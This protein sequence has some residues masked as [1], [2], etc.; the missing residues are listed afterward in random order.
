MIKDT[1]ELI[2]RDIYTEM[3]PGHS[4]SV[5]HRAFEVYLRDLL[6]PY[7]TER[8]LPIVFRGRTIGNFRCDLIVDGSTIVELKSISRLRAQE[9]QQL[10]NYM[11][12]LEGHDGILINFG[13]TNLEFVYEKCNPVTENLE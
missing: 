2:A 7:E 3:G 11:K 10:N 5:Y 8:I 4:E 9:H 6:I 12:L 1:I 13:P